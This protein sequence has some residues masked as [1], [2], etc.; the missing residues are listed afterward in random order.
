MWKQD[1]NVKTDKPGEVNAPRMATLGT[2]VFVKGEMTG[3]EDLT[4]D[5]RVEGKIDLP[6]HA[7]TIGPN[8]TIQASI[9]AK[10]M[11]VFGTVVGTLNVKEK[12]DVRKSASVEGTVTCGRMTVQEGAHVS[13]KLQTEKVRR[14]SAD[15]KGGK[16]AA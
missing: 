10:N 3:S 9:T 2:S 14:P 16:A 15:A 7:L 6:D 12:L 11:T 4:I 8:A 1:E 13:G 5:G